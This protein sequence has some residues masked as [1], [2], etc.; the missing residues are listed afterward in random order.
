MLPTT[1]VTLKVLI[2]C[3]LYIKDNTISI[4]VSNKGMLIQTLV[5]SA[6]SDNLKRLWPE[7]SPMFPLFL[8][9][10]WVYHQLMITSTRHDLSAIVISGLF[11]Q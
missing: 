2:N 5:I 10:G 3:I 6:I 8:F 11:Y 7:S 9:G 4:Y 1:T